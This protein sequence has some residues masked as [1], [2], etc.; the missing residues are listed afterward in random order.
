M[1]LATSEE[2]AK[3]LINEIFMRFGVLR[4]VVSDNVVQFVSA[5]MQKAMLCLGIKESLTPLYHPASNPIERK[6]R[7]VKTQPGI[8]VGNQ[9]DQWDTHLPVIRFAMNSTLCET[10]GHTPVCLTFA[11]ELRA[12][13]SCLESCGQKVF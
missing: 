5:V 10:N 9:H 11:R 13:D 12:P 3:I 4:K 1:K 8:L 6:T 2:C 7:D